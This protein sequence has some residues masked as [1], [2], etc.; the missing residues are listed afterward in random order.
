MKFWRIVLGIAGMLFIIIGVLLFFFLLALND[1]EVEGDS[2]RVDVVTYFISLIPI[3][4]G[5]IILIL[6]FKT[7]KNKNLN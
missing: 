2:G 1:P 6:L 4:S 5:G 3:I 7:K